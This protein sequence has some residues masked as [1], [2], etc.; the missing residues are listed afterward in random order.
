[1]K[2]LR[3]QMRRHASERAIAGELWQEHGLVFTTT[4]GTAYEPHNLRRDFRKVTSAARAGDSL[5]TE[6]TADVIRQHDE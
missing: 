4:V 2:A 5:G 6:G 3:G 1:V